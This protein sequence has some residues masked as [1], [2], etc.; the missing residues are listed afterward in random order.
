MFPRPVLKTKLK[1]TGVHMTMSLTVFAYLMYQIYYNWYPEPY[2]SIDGGWQGMRLI[3]AV[4]LVLGPFIPFLIFDLRKTRRAILFDL[5]TILVI[6]FGALAYGIYV[7]YTQRPVALVLIDDFVVSATME[8]YGG[9]LESASDLQRYSDEKPPII[10]ADLPRTRAGL[11][12]AQRIKFE[13]KVLEHA[14]MR[15]Y[16]PK[17]EL[18]T[19]LQQ[20]QMR[21]MA[22]L[23]K[24]K[25]RPA[26][27]KWLR[28]HGK[29]A[30]EVYLE[31]FT[32]RYGYAWLVF[33]L[34]ARLIGYFYN[35]A[36]REDL[37]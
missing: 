7:T 26:F 34:D 10:Y 13:E 3:G 24:Y 28:E 9:T 25:G 22:L 17:S 1:A 27:D 2:F 20:R 32:A 12:E 36:V 11:D 14:Q 5:I 15:L 30:D 23:D 18:K 16:Q 35:D 33:D 6:Q 31:R 19:A 29:Q 21:V 8:H 4:D 37:F